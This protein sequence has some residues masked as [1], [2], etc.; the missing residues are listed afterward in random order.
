MQTFKITPP[1]YGKKHVLSTQCTGNNVPAP[2][3]PTNRACLL[4]L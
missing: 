1:P 4:Q 3:P 2:E